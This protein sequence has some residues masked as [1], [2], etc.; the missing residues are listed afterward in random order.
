MSI[1][2]L[3][4][5]LMLSVLTFLSLNAESLLGMMDHVDIFNNGK[6]STHAIF[7]F[8]NGC[9]P[10][11][12]NSELNGVITLTI[13][14][15]ESDLVNLIDKKKFFDEINDL[16]LI[17]LVEVDNEYKK[18]RI[19]LKAKTGATVFTFKYSNKNAYI[20]YSEIDR[21]RFKIEIFS[22]EELKKISNKVDGPLYLALNTEASALG[23]VKKKLNKTAVSF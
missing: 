12:S 10:T 22:K 16:K 14:F 23:V 2:K 15:A 18:S 20:K 21:N 13:T 4:L 17:D 6:I 5:S 3:V 1:N 11:V 8:K 19:G 7:S 9:K